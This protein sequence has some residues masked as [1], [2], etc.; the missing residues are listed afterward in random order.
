MITLPGQRKRKNKK[1]MA[2]NQLPVIKIPCP[3]GLDV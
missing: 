2:E 1:D 3:N